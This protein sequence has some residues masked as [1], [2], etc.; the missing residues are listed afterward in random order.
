L[1]KLVTKGRGEFLRQ[2]RSIASPECR[3]LL[4]E[5]ADPEIFR[6]CKLDFTERQKHAPV[7]KLY[8]DLL[9]I[10]REDP[11]IRESEFV[12]GAVLGRDA[13]VLRYFSTVGDDRLLLMNLGAD[14]HLNPAP[15]PLL[16]PLERAGWRVLWS[17]E[18]TEYGGCGTPPVE[19][20]ANWFIPA[21]AAVLMEPDENSELPQVKLSQND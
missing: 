12:D 20:A 13:F 16:A 17:S 6:Q 8:T 2:F 9:R 5:P 1:N 4:A 19:T 10:R 7:Y 18:S 15:E 3:A 11:T 14:L 21:N